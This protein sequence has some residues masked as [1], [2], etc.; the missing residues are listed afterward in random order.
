AGW[1]ARSCGAAAPPSTAA[2]RSR[3]RRARARPAAASAAARSDRRRGGS[4]RALRVRPGAPVWRWARRRGVGCSGWRLVLA[5]APRPLVAVV[6]PQV[7]LRALQDHA[8]D[9]AVDDRHV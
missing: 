5:L 2:S 8:F 9:L 7:L 1:S 6:A 3:C 4:W